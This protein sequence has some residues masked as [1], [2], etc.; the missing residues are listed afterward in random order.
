MST[1]SKISEDDWIFAERGFEKVH[2]KELLSCFYYACRYLSLKTHPNLETL[3]KIFEKPYKPKKKS[4]PHTL[5]VKFTDQLQLYRQ[6][7][8]MIDKECLDY[9]GFDPKEADNEFLY[10]ETD[11]EAYRRFLN[12]LSEKSEIDG[13][14]I[15]GNRLAIALHKNGDETIDFFDPHGANEIT[16]HKNAAY[17]KKCHTL[18]EAAQF[19]EMRFPAEPEGGDLSQPLTVWVIQYK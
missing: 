1:D 12:L 4:D 8:Y 14:I 13:A 3:K 15:A 7:P 17:I 10:L 2:P 6:I 5:F 9:F 19:L 16:Q 11:L 18:E